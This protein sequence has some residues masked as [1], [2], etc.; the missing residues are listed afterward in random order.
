MPDEERVWTRVALGNLKHVSQVVEVLA[1]TEKAYNSLYSFFKLEDTVSLLSYPLSPFDPASRVR[2][3]LFEDLLAYRVKTTK[4]YSAPVPMEH[5]LELV[6]YR[7]ESP[8]LFEIIGT[9]ASVLYIV[10]ALSRLV[11]RH[12]PMLENRKKK[13]K[14]SEIE[15]ITQESEHID[16]ALANI[17][18]HGLS[19][20]T[21][22][23]FIKNLVVEP[24]HR[25][26]R[27]ID[28]GSIRDVK[29]IDPK[30]ENG[31]QTNDTQKN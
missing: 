18:L 15:S 13:T 8:G 5:K 19:K 1:D 6:K 25:L 21:V 30:P 2:T 12:S 28:N 24:L 17:R 20:T 9:V 11:E 22:N 26:A 16:K 4:D 3:K 10:E 31:D 14:V 27:H 7:I 23:M 29:R